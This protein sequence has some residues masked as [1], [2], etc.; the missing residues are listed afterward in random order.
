MQIR[1]RVII[2]AALRG[3]PLP[4]LP[5]P[6]HATKMEHLTLPSWFIN[7]DEHSTSEVSRYRRGTAPHREVSLQAS[8][9]DLVRIL[10]PFFSQQRLTLFKSLHSDTQIG[11]AHV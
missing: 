7:D 5:Q 8:M 1:R 11:R 4:E 10:P 9:S 3:L 2:K 6:S